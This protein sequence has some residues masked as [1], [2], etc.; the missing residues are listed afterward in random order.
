M[1]VDDNQRIYIPTFD[2][3]PAAPNCPTNY[4]WMETRD[5][6]VRVAQKVTTSSGEDRQFPKLPA[7]KILPAA[8]TEPQLDYA[9]QSLGK[10]VR[11][12]IIDQKLGCLGTRTLAGET[13]T[14]FNLRAQHVTLAW[15]S[16]YIH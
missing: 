12:R 8:S 7:D 1:L 3:A 4:W 16:T 14:E 11:A 2:L 15:E 6:K 10:E 5:P 13:G 9:F